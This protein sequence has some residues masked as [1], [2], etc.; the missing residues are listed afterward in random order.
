[1]SVG[2]IQVTSPL[3]SQYEYSLDWDNF[4]SSPNFTALPP[5][6]H[7]LI[8]HLVQSDCYSEPLLVTINSMPMVTMS[9]TNNI[10]AGEPANLYFYGTPNA[11]VVF[12]TNN[13]PN[14]SILIDSSGFA[15]YTSAPLTT[16]TS[17][18]L[19][20][21]TSGSIVCNQNLGN[22][23]LVTVTTCIPN[24][25]FHLNAFLDNNNNGIQDTG[26]VN[27]PFGQFHYQVNNT[28]HNVF[29]F[30]GTL[31][32]TENNPS[33]LYSFGFT[34]NSAF[35]NY[36]IVNPLNYTNMQIS[37][38]GG[39]TNINFA[40]SIS[41]FTDLSITNLPL[42]EPIPG[43]NYQHMLLYSNNGLLSA[44]GNI[45]FIKDPAVSMINISEPSALINPNG[46]TYNFTNLPPLQTG[47]II[48][49][50]YVP[51]LPNVSLGQL[52]ITSASIN[53]SSGGDAIP[54]NN[55]SSSYQF[56]S[57]SYDPNDI[58]ES[59]GRDILHSSFS[60]EDYLY[61]TIRFE[62]TGNGNA[63]NISID[64]LLDSKLDESTLEMVSSSHNYIMD[65]ISNT[66]NWKFNNIQLPPSVSNSNVGKGYVMYKIKPKTGY[67]LGDIIPNTAE[68]FFDTNPAVVTNTFENEFVSQLSIPEYSN[69]T[70]TVYPNPAKEQITIQLSPNNFIKQVELVDVLGRIIMIKHY[71]SSNTTEILSLNE[72]E[73]GTYL[74]EITTDNNQKATKKIL[75]N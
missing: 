6:E 73:K 20:S 65:R 61:Y 74:L 56:V 27:V 40:I 17:Y 33:T 71:T 8:V 11:T 54:S 35:S 15:V 1:M 58:V 46:F 55:T 14:Q 37:S 5:G 42:S 29:S 63:I 41:S 57:G 45:N 26:E 36:F 49:T 31:H 68:I 9:G 24:S 28:T 70:V 59:H 30:S 51:E 48:A 72:V 19:V 4:Q 25:G 47:T 38:T 69:N 62:N 67:A 60:S 50:M 39:I 13:G 43:F 66:V 2:Q 52:L 44:S 18:N 3:G 21:I 64:N 7:Y 75:V 34:I 10:C 23:V 16:N 12:N 22:P 32:I 53:S